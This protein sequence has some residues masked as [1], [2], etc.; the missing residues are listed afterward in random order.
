MLTAEPTEARLHLGTSGF[1]YGDWRGP[2]YPSHLRKDQWLEFYATKF[3]TVEVNS[4]YYRVAAPRT[5]EKMRQRVPDSFLFSVK[6]PGTLTHQRGRDPRTV[7]TAFLES[8]AP[9]GDGPILLQFPSSF[10][11]SPQ[12]RV[13]LARAIDALGHER[14]VFEPRHSSW[15]R[16]SV[17]E[18]LAQRGVAWCAVDLP[19]LPGLPGATEHVTGDWA[20][21]RLHGRNQAT[22][23]K[24]EHAWQRYDYTYTADEL[25]PWVPRIRKML[26]SASRVHI[27]ANNH[28]QGEAIDTLGQLST[29]LR[30]TNAVKISEE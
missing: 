30:Q 4:T 9:L 26:E 28:F 24:H 19:A 25:K 17:F 3:E 20:Y 29:L 11:W 6:A 15:L 22:W 13:Y 10:R 7:A 18:G 23:W 21:I 1:S 16:D 12:N 2:F 8:V 27:Y 5:Y 14:S